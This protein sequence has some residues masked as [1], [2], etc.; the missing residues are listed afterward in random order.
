MKRL[1]HN[2]FTM[3]EIVIVI[4][5]I[6]VIGSMA[7]SILSQGSD[8]YVNETNRQGFVSEARSSFW[9][10]IR[11]TQ[12]QVSPKDFSNSGINNLGLKNSKGESIDFLKE[13]TGSFKRKINDGSYKILSDALS[14][15]QSSFSYFDNNFNLITPSQS[16]L[17][18]EEAKTVHLIKL[19]LTFLEN[20]DTIFLSSYIYP[21]N[22][23]LGTP[24]TYHKYE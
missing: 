22:F 12:G 9:R 6:G 4:V 15:S 1:A 23:R 10:I 7:A 8:I 13:S 2:G 3:I 19:D 16:N 11:E 24:M 18:D 14:F 5:L 20:Q 17:S 21:N